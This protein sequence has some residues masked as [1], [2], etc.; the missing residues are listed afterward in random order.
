[1]NKII[2][3]LS[4]L[5]LFTQVYLKLTEEKRNELLNKYTKK[6]SFQNLDE[7]KNYEIKFYS[8]PLKEG[9]QYDPARIESLILEYGLPLE[10]NFINETNATSNVK[11]QGSCGCCWS[12]AATTTLAYRYHKKGIEV[13][14]SPQDGLSCYIKDCDAGNY[15]IDPQL[16]LIKNGTLTEGCLPFSSSD[17]KTIVPC[18]ESCKD[19][20][21]FKRYYAQNAYMT[22]DYYSEETF[23][24]I[25]LLI[26]DQLLNNGPVTSNIVVYEDFQKLSQNPKKCH[27]EVY[28]YDGTSEELG[29]HAVVIVGYGYLK[30]KFYWLIQNSWGEDSCDHGFIKVEFGQITVENI[31][32]S[33]PY[34]HNEESTT[35]EIPI[36]FESFDE[37]CFPKVFTN[38][39]YNKWKNTLDI[40]FE[41]TKGIKDIHF[42][43]GSNDIFNKGNIAKCY[44]EFK[45]YYAP[46]GTYKLKDFQSLGT[47]NTFILD[48]SFD[49]KTFEFFGFDTLQ[50]NYYPLNFVS[51]KGSRITFY[52]GL[53]D[54]STLPSIYPNKKSSTPL[55]VCK[56]I[57]N[58]PLMYCDIQE[59]ELDSFRDIYDQVYEPIVYNILCGYKQPILLAFR[60][61]KKVNAAFRIKSFIF[62]G[63]SIYYNS[64]LTLVSRVEGSVSLYKNYDNT[65][66]TFVEVEKNRKNTTYLMLCSIGIPY[67]TNINHN[68]N[69]VFVIETD[70]TVKY[71]NLYL[72][73]YYLPYEMNAMYEVIISETI[74]SKDHIDPDPEPEPPTPDNNWSPNNLKIPLIFTFVLL[75]MF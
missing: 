67:S 22:G 63:K 36:F 48:E 44:Y 59:N 8:E 35:E 3:Y 74:K 68:L 64:K 12:H 34:I 55:K 50:Y 70:T 71:D 52:C 33:E 25:V 75:L 26:I 58:L 27:D 66:V 16:N 17:G 51:E 72:L 28:T 14:L 42:Q 61:N 5:F 7:L 65:F 24:D 13:D 38:L 23:E 1:M 21:E 49:K 56:K 4:F 73:P 41:H 2:F 60:L 19:G 46:K 32:F 11:D 9:I 31:V 39:D 30:G 53:D 43:C 18:P 29:G 45:N 57:D 69:C 40:T 6:V 37:L 62:S 20:S 47:E 10:Y 15:V 54:E